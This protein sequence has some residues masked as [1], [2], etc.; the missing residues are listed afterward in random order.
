M[1]DGFS[2]VAYFIFLFRG[3]FRSRAIKGGYEKHRIVSE[4]VFAAR[5]ID[6]G[7]FDG[8]EC[9]DDNTLWISQREV[10]NEPG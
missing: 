8:I 6:Y 10:A 3:K 7:P 4:T 5:L 2:A 1:S 9:F